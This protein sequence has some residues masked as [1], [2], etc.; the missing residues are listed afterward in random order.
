MSASVPSLPDGVISALAAVVG[1]EHV[2]V[3]PELRAGHEVDWT[4]RYRG[5]TP[6]VVRPADTAEVAEVLALCDTERIAVVPQG[7]N[8]GLVGGGVPLHGELV[9]SLRRLD[10]LGPV[11]EVASQ[12]TAGAGCTLEAVQSCAAP[13]LSPRR[14]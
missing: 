12:V 2:L 7:G 5:R 6:A 1:Q 8:T 14:Q 3:D 11:D 13:L 9:L 10:G 4:R